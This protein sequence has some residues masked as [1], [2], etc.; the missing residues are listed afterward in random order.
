MD[1]NR[2]FLPELVVSDGTV[3]SEG[4]GPVDGEPANLGVITASTDVVAVDSVSCEIMGFEVPETDY[5]AMAARS[6]LGMSDL[7]QIEIAGEE[8][9]SVRGPFKRHAVDFSAQRFKVVEQAPVAVAST[10]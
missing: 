4:Y 1:L 5:L 9:A 3:E 8:I 10:Q 6:R 7:D 2:A